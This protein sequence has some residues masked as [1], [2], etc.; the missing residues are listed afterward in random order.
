MQ[1]F[2]HCLPVIQ[3]FL[4]GLTEAERQLVMDDYHRGGRAIATVMSAKLAYWNC[5]PWKLA[6]LL[7]PVPTLARTAARECVEQYDKTPDT[8]HHHRL[9]N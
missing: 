9:S 2:G 1:V 6:G 4:N 5:L 8:A 7:H 3:P